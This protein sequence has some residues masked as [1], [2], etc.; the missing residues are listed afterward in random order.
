MLFILLF[1][2]KFKFSLFFLLF[3]KIIISLKAIFG[4][5]CEDK[6]NIKVF[7]KGENIKIKFIFL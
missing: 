1:S 2:L 6:K 4:F 5:N 7:L 3:V